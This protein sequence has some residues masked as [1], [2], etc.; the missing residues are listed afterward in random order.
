[1]PGKKPE[2]I[3]FNKG[4][5]AYKKDWNNFAP[6]VAF[7]WT[8]N[9]PDGF[10]RTLFGRDGDSVL[11]AG[12]SLAYS[13]NGTS[14]FSGV[15][16]SNPGVTVSANRSTSL[17]GSNALNNDGRG[18]P[19]MFRDRDRLEPP[20]FPLKREYPLTDVITGDVQIFD[21][22]IVVPYAQTWTAGWQR[23]LSQDMAFEIRYVG[24]RSD[25]GWTAY[26][27]NEANIVENG[28]LNEF[29]LAQQN[30]RAH[31]ALGCGAEGQPDCSFAYRGP[32]TG[33]SPLPIY[34]A[35]LNGRTNA[36]SAS[37]Y[38]GS[39]WT[40]SN[41]IDPLNPHDPTPFTPAG[42]G[43][44]T[45]LDGNST[46][47]ANAAAAGLPANFFRANPDLQGG[48]IVTGNGLSARFH[49]MQLELRKRLSKGLQVQGSY[50]FGEAREN[51]RHSFR[52]PRTWRLDTGG[53][54]GVTH[55]FKANWV[56]ELP[57][58]QGRRFGGSVG[59]WL[60]RLI[61]GWSVDGIAR[62]QS[63]RMVDFGNV[64]LVGMT[65]E[66][67][68]KMFKLQFDRDNRLIFMLPQDVIDNTVRAFSVD[69]TS[70]NGYG[71]LGAPQGRYFAPANGPDCIEVAG[72]FGDCGVR[73]LV[74]TGPRQ[75]RFDLSTTKR[76][77]ITARTNAEFRAE[78]LNAFNT[79][80]FTPVTGIGDDPN[81]Y[82]VT[83]GVSGRTIQIVSRFSW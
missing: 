24:T 71:D 49:G 4:D 75:V 31:V 38:T 76:V 56:Y 58:G 74:V 12:Y 1:M 39:A 43:S 62:I 81:D 57:F 66:D 48:G 83:G 79:T 7:N 20:A 70:P 35:Y 15:F 42:T 59:P 33:T 9:P 40:S 37:A 47:R 65:K 80:Y 14:D 29:R 2:Y 77:R 22:D 73:T 36:D 32:G 18:L 28:F 13:R 34:L 51:V 61:G 11:R 68:S 53:E 69:A 41:W 64:Q 26:N 16:G 27:Y 55:A 23:K 45:G 46:R 5:F 25:Q 19:L 10:L 50:A 78:F 6:T 21:P 67:V 72:G 8:L 82:R 60:D 54:G 63:G 52:T 44:N 3:P 30:L 17:T